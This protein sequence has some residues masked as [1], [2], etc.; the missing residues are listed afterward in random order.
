MYQVYRFYRM[1]QQLDVSAV[2]CLTRISIFC[3]VGERDRWLS[4]WPLLDVL[5]ETIGKASFGLEV[6][7]RV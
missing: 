2:T 4:G 6:R 1:L 5:R 3:L 7:A